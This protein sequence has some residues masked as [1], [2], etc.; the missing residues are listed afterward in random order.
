MKTKLWIFIDWYLP[1]YKA[2]GPI[3]SV[4]NLTSRL[5]DEFTI[6]ILTSSLDLGEPLDLAPKELNVW[7][8][9]EGY[10]VMY[11]DDNHQNKNF[12]KQLF[13]SNDFDVVY[14]NSLFSLK[15]TLL[16]LWLL[17]DQSIR[18]VLATR[19]MLGKGAL[20]IKPFKKKLFLSLFR[21]FKLHKKV[22]WHATAE[23]EVD[24]IKMHFGA[25]CT[26]ILAPNLSALSKSHL[27]PKVKKTGEVQLFFLSRI[28]FKKNL[29]GALTVL[30]EIPPAHQINFSIIGPIE[31]EAYW[32]KCLVKIK[33][34][35]EHVKVNYEGAIPNH[36]LSEHLKDAHVLFLPTFHENFGH[37]IMEA[38]QNGCPV[39]ISD[40]TPWRD[41]ER[42]RLGYD[43]PIVDEAAFVEAVTHFSNMPQDEFAK[44]SKASFDYAK[45]FVDDPDVLEMNRSLFLGD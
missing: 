34:L 9:K 1:A 13:K 19:G 24:E 10:R 42:Q 18:R 12:Y 32:E 33:T 37:V 4:A 22:V 15:F 3:Q 35:P 17:R 25:E 7:V 27:R 38:W 26:I 6:S 31:D 5:K 23:T 45:A 44:W 2:G 39:I 21:F 30:S 43:L 8:Q 16:P 20:A 14:F 28:S 36:L 40:Q 29:L 41:L 11:L